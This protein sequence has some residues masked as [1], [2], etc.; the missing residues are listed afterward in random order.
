MGGLGAPSGGRD[1]AAGGELSLA[2]IGLAGGLLVGNFATFSAYIEIGSDRADGWI[3]LALIVATSCLTISVIQGGWRRYNRQA[4]YGLVGVIATLAAPVVAFS[5]RERAQ[6]ATAQ[7][8]SDLRAE[9]TAQA[10]RID[11]LDTRVAT[12]TA[13]N[14]RAMALLTQVA[15]TLASAAASRA[16]PQQQQPTAPAGSHPVP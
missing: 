4:I 16:A 2:L 10:A 5:A 3:A 11:A 1:A 12:L 15:D 13:E 9:V 14:A 7:A 8:I 6:D